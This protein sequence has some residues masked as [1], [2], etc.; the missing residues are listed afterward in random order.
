MNKKNWAVVLFIIAIIEYFFPWFNWFLFESSKV[1][2]WE[3]LIIFIISLVWWL[4]LWYS[5]EKIEKGWPK[6]KLGDIVLITNNIWVTTQEIIIWA[7]KDDFPYWMYIFSNWWVWIDLYA[8]PE[9]EITK[10]IWT[11]NLPISIESKEILKFMKKEDYD[12][13][14]KD[15][16][17]NN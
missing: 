3:W 1:S 2:N 7:Y 12:Y 8:R 9:N 4:L 10:K 16:I 14:I 17:Y 11:T 15:N 6:Y 5:S 13:L